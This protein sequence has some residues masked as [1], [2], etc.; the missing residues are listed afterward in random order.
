M[1]V[2]I[3]SNEQYNIL[4]IFILTELH[5]RSAKTKNSIHPT[6]ISGNGDDYDDYDGD[7][8]DDSSSLSG[9]VSNWNMLEHLCHDT[10][11]VTT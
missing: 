2:H 4:S 9:S 8:D 10:V 3:C 7:D 1:K 6:L 5:L 11:T